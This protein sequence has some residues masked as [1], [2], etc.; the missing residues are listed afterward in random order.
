MAIWEQVVEILRESIFVYAQ[1]TGG[2]LGGGILAVT[3]LVRLALFPLTLRVARLSAVHQGRMRRLQPELDALRRRFNDD[4][5]RLAEE[6]RRVFAREGVSL[7]PR[8]GCLG[9]LVQMPVL[10][11]LF[12]AVRRVSTQGGRF[13]WIGSIARP[14]FILAGLVAALT[15]AAVAFGPQSMPQGRALLI[16]LPTVVTLV[17]L[18]QMAAGIGLS[19]GV[20]SLA[21]LLQ[22]IVLRRG[23][24]PLESPA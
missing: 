8:A 13:L 20:S 5:G 3:L 1:A 14:D 15:G 6:T 17:A 11:A 7:M 4:Q 19:W 16:I 21:S 23:R 2:N 9:M 12:S 10:L 24:R 18:S 22:A